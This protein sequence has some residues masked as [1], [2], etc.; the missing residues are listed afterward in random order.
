MTDPNDQ[1]LS[2]TA[3]EPAPAVSDDAPVSPQ[4]AAPRTV[5]IG[6][7]IAAV[8]L[9]FVFFV[10]PALVDGNGS[11]PNQVATASTQ[12]NDNSRVTQATEPEGVAGDERSPFAEAQ[13]SKIR[14]EAQEILQALLT[15]QDDLVERGVA[16]WGGAIYQQALAA[17]TAGDDAYRAREFTLATQQYQAALEALEVLAGELPDRMDALHA[18][19]IGAIESADPLAANRGFEQMQRMAPEDIRLIDLAL[20][21]ASLPTV[22]D[23]LSQADTAE[24]AGALDSALAA[25]RSAASADP[26]HQRAAAR[27]TELSE[28]LTQQRFTEAMSA[29]YLHLTEN[30]FDRAE[31]QFREAAR[32][33]PGAP[34]PASALVELEQARTLAKLMALKQQAEQA[35]REER[36]SDAAQQFRQALEIDDRVIFATE[37]LARVEP[38]AALDAR[39]AAIPAERDRLVDRRIMSLAE[40]T[41]AEAEAIAQPGPRLQSQ[42][43]SARETIR[44]ASTPIAVTIASDG[45]TDITLLRV[46][47]LGTVAQEQLS[48][49]PGPYTAVGIRDGFR[50]VRISFEV[51]PDGENRVDVR[52]TEAI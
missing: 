22:I 23:Y 24:A 49:R 9:L 1:P 18:E 2:A 19:I 15:L 42:I 28:A 11:T 7:G 33:R 34:E 26:M 36:W 25:A 12:S 50:D 16:D 32:I 17:A 29:G 41:V 37:G 31:Q 6:F 10:L 45:L 38:R 14:R 20:R 8:L 35:E 5:L 51:R 3:F 48:L 40:A 43:A 39:L 4:A 30:Q 13:L 27:V 47:R 44:Y 46:R 52:C 21:I